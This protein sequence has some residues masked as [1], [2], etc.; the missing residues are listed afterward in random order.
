MT[1]LE[2]LLN[3][4]LTKHC[5]LEI[6]KQGDS[7]QVRFQH[8]GRQLIFIL[9]SKYLEVKVLD[10]NSIPVTIYSRNHYEELPEWIN[11]FI[12]D[13]YSEL[14]SQRYYMMQSEIKWLR[15]EDEV[16]PQNAEIREI[17]SGIKRCKEEEV[18]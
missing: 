17:K 14:N 5:G 6:I 13:C 15:E 12:E 18:N 10:K 2:Q 1:E 8:R 7:T 3:G 16:K 11:N 4:Y 9:V